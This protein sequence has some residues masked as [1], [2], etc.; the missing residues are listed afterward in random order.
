[1]E[2]GSLKGVFI[3]PGECRSVGNSIEL[4]CSLN[5]LYKHGRPFISS[6]QNRKGISMVYTV[7]YNMSI[8]WMTFTV[9]IHIVS[10]DI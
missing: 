6:F 2:Q 9:H 5:T 10:Y 4:C 7:Y 8:Q 1:M 3:D